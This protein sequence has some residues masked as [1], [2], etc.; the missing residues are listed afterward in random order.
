MIGCTLGIV[1]FTSGYEQ[2]HWLLKILN[3]LLCDVQFNT[4]MFQI[5]DVYLIV[6]N[7]N[8]KYKLLSMLYFNNSKDF[9]LS[10]LF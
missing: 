3:T 6:C 9:I 2:Q 5:I 10:L 7:R 4:F 8:F 1:H